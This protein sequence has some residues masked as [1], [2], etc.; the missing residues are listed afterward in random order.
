MAIRGKNLKDVVDFDDIVTRINEG[1]TY[2][3]IAE[4]LDVNEKSLSAYM[5]RNGFRTIKKN[6][7]THDTNNIKD[8]R[9]KSGMSLAD[10]GNVIGVTREAVRQHEQ[11]IKQ[12][13]EKNAA[14]YAELFGVKSI[15]QEGD[16]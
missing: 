10:V 8:L 15:Y 1:E 2:Q 14:K 16:Q 4:D 3:E 6:P 9:A 7:H 5:V 11:N 13:S 12:P